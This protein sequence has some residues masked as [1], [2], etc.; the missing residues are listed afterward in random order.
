MATPAIFFIHMPGCG[1][2]AKTAP[3]FARAAAQLAKVAGVRSAPVDI[4]KVDWKAKRW[5]PRVTPSIVLI[6][7][8]RMVGVIEGQ[9]TAEQIYQWALSKL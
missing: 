7:R 1:A 8:G 3:Q 5:I 2:C 6:A 9:A 4:T